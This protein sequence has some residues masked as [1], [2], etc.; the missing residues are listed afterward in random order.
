MKIYISGKI[1]GLKPEEYH[2]K[3]EQAETLLREK[4]FQNIVNPTKLGIHPTEDWTRAMAIC[5]SHLETC[6]AIYM[7]DSWRE[8]FG[9]RH[10][11]TRA[12]ERRIKVMFGPEDIN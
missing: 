10:E 3:F 12:Q 11:L 8:S 7:L 5:M 1:T 4:G 6:D 2:P 9:A